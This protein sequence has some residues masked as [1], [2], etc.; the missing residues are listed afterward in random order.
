[1]KRFE[2]A[3]L[4]HEMAD[5]LDIRGESPFKSRAYRQAAGALLLLQ[6][7]IEEMIEHGELRKMPGFGSALTKKAEEWL[8]TG[9]IEAHERLKAEVP[10]ELT[11]LMELP[12][13]GPKTAQA[14]YRMGIR[15]LA[16]LEARALAGELST[17]RGLG[18]KAEANILKGLEQMRARAKM[19]PIGVALHAAVPVFE[20]VRNQPGVKQVGF[21][22]GIRRMCE[23]LEGVELVAAG[24]QSDR[25]V[26]EIATGCDI[27]K[28]LEQDAPNGSLH[29]RLSAG[30][31][32]TLHV[33]PPDSFALALHRHTGS[34]QHLEQLER[35]AVD[36]A[37]LLTGEGLFDTRA[38]NRVQ[39]TTEAD[40]YAALDLAFIPPELREG[41]NEIEAAARRQI[42]QLVRVKDIQ[43]DL[44]CHTRYSDGRLTLSAL[45]EA[46][47][48]KGLS[49]VAVTDHS[50]SLVVAGGLSAE[51]HREQIREIDKLNDV[52]SGIR[53]L[54]GIEV[55][56][57]PDGELDA[58]PDLL[59]EI[60]VVVASVHTA[61]HQ[62]P[63]RMTDRLV[64][65]IQS[66]WVDIL[67][68]PTGRKLGRRE[69]YE[70]DLQ[71]VVRA[72]VEAGVAIEINASPNR[73]DLGSDL[74]AAAQS[75][76]AD[77]FTINSDA[78]AGEEV[79][80]LGLG[81]GVARKAWVTPGMV[82]NT[83][84]LPQLLAR[85][86]KNR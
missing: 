27:G 19:I 52:L 74:C 54:T 71:A 53:L 76:G 58:E 61:F 59:K 24:E 35:W 66:G 3:R 65:A 30:V 40:L 86:H 69:P 31:P 62:E 43:G 39:I 23:T 36:R 32:V 6:G 10:V 82:L 48:A 8:R 49:Y 25:L 5:L 37:M 13:V 2:L 1:M 20:W 45:A 44:H 56:I 50:R 72:A 51:R 42:P 78:H 77:L 60:D 83:L 7:D 47:Q 70:F 75:F 73:L 85:L 28:V 12:G 21:A 38:K 80:N 14:L 17:A 22:G 84:P 9:R 26:E 33:V 18:P 81:V 34:R 41:R 11:R 57:L 15:T 68:H 64:R 67:G 4:F 16:E 63:Q 55:D 46:A 29:I 79:G